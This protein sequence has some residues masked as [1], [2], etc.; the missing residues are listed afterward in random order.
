M[1]GPLTHDDVE[2]VEGHRSPTAHR[3]LADTVLGWADD[4]HPEDEVSVAELLAEA[5]W[6]LDLAG[7][8]DAALAVFDRSLAAG[9]TRPDVR[10]S[11]VAV[12]LA[13]DRTAEAREVA[14]A[15]RRA[16]PAVP[17]CAAMAEVWELAGE[18]E[19]AARWT[20]IG[21][22]RL[23]LSTDEDLDAG[24]AE[25]LLTTRARVRAAQGL[26]PD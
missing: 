8:T 6:H 26:P 12:L 17:D 18:L 21:L 16:R 1:R 2:A 13:C 24:E 9:S 4:P 22:A 3:A 5:G 20:A 14:D 23:E 10:C 7:D 19:Q 25:L 11:V 15:L